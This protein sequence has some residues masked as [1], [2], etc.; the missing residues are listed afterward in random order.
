MRETD[1]ILLEGTQKVSHA[2]GP[3]TKQY[4]CRN[5]GYS[6]LGVL[7]CLLGRQGLTIA[8]CEGKETGSGRPRKY[9]SVLSQRS[10]FQHQN[11]VP[12][13]NL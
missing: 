1:T 4:L 2:L 11:L 10:T 3:S 6:Y 7:E 8:H 13:N 9:Q 12:P 5:L